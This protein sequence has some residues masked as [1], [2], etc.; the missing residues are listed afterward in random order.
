MIRFLRKASS[1]PLELIMFI[2]AAGMATY[3]LFFLSPFYSGSLAAAIATPLSVSLAPRAL[4]VAFGVLFLLLAL[5]G[6]LVPFGASTSW[7]RWSSTLLFVDFFFLALLRI[8]VI[9]WLP[10]IWLPNALIALSCLVMN[11]HF[12]EEIP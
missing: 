11:A 4:E 6:L 10:V 3:F 9:G 2:F 7:K 8:M 12:R 1:N 5:P